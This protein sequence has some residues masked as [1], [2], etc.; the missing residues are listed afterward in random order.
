MNLLC[1]NKTEKNY[2]KNYIILCTLYIYI[3]L[4]KYDRK[5]FIHS[6][7]FYSASQYPTDTVLEFHAEASQATANEALAQGPYVAARAGFVPVTL[8][9]KGAE[10]TNEPP[11]PTRNAVHYNSDKRTSGRLPR[12]ESLAAKSMGKDSHFRTK[13]EKVKGNKKKTN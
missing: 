1:T 8:Q 4:T 10:S 6:G 5:P 12:E 11:R 2:N 13:R 3:P 7:Y 9:T